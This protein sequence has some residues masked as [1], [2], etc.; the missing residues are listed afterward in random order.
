MRHCHDIPTSG[1]TE[2]MVAAI[3]T[4][5][6]PAVGLECLDYVPA[7]QINPSARRLARPDAPTITWSWTMI[8]MWRAASTRSRVTR[9]S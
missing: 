7:L 9:M 3:D 8:F 4:E 2:M 5:Q 1:V 6:V